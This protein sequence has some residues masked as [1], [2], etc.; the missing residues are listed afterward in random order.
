MVELELA[1]KLKDCKTFDT[2]VSLIERVD[3]LPRVREPRFFEEALNKTLEPK[4]E[5]A[6]TRLFRRNAICQSKIEDQLKQRRYVD[7]QFPKIQ[8]GLDN[9]L[10]HYSLLQEEHSRL[11]ADYDA[12]VGNLPIKKGITFVRKVAKKL[13]NSRTNQGTSHE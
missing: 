3:N 5:E 1:G 12:I 4:L 9:A 8:E 2:K 7:D 11:S 13:R 6:I 10:H